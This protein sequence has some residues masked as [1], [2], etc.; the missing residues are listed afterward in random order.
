MDVRMLV[1]VWGVALP[2]PFARQTVHAWVFRSSYPEALN[3]CVYDHRTCHLS[4]LSV[5]G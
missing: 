3:I 1:C 4:M 5:G 2:M